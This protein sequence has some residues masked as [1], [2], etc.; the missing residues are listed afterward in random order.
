MGYKKTADPRYKKHECFGKYF[1]LKMVFESYLINDRYLSKGW[2]KKKTLDFHD[3]AS[4]WMN[5]KVDLNAHIKDIDER[6]Y[7]RH[8]DCV[9]LECW[10]CSKIKKL[11]ISDY[12]NVIELLHYYT[13]MLCKLDLF[14]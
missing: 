2:D 13:N 5:K 8:C 9:I 4:I 11:L 1:K 6:Y 14:F 7:N 12:D 10:K 3:L